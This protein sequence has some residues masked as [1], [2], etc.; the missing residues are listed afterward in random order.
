MADE[1]RKPDADVDDANEF[2]DPEATRLVSGS[3]AALEPEVPAIAHA[4]QPD[5]LGVGEHTPH[6]AKP[7]L[8]II[9]G[10]DMGQ[11][12]VLDERSFVVGRGEGCDLRLDD[13]T[14]SRRHCELT[15]VGDRLTA[16]DLGSRNGTFV[17][18]EVL[19]D[20]VDVRDGDVL[21]VGRTLLKFLG[22][23]NV[24]VAYFE[25]IHRAM[26]TDGLTGALNRRGLDA[27]LERRWYEWR[28]YKR[29]FSVVMFDLDH[30]KAVNDTYGHRVGDRVLA[31]VG[32]IVLDM[33][34]LSDAFGRYGG[35]EFVLLLPETPADAACLV[36][37]RL[38]ARVAEDAFVVEEHRIPV[39]ISL[40][41][42]TARS[43]VQSLDELIEEVDGR[44]YQAKQ[45]GRNRVSPEPRP[46]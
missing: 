1:P 13:D 38:R 11:R 37:E 45:G 16:R 40:G 34:R 25:E 21:R 18:D 27:E 20:T 22:G 12:Y 6:V 7:T 23:R 32:K 30:F 17:N 39:T 36:A 26:T 31:R 2:E 4:T 14:A 41:V 29:S 9:H 44:L 15:L 10:N 8:V 33:K 43:A 46:E 35:E 28:R 19:A 5:V 3:L 42:A 24:E